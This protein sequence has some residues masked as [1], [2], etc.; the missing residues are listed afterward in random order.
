MESLSQNH[1]FVDG[2]K[3]VAISV[4]A[5]FLCINGFRLQFDDLTTYA[6][7]IRLYEANDFR[8]DRLVEWLTPCPYCLIRPRDSGDHVFP[9]F[10]GGTRKTR[11]CKKCNDNFGHRFEGPVSNDLAP[12]IVFL[13]FSGYKHNRLVMHRRA[14]VDETTGVEYDIDSE[15]RS[16]PNK[17]YLIRDED[18]KV[19]QVVARNSSEAQKIV[20][21][22]KA[23]GQVKEVIER[24]ETKKGLRPP[25]RNTCINV[26]KEMRQLALKMCA[27]VGQV[28]VPEIGILDESCR[29]FLLDLNPGTSPVRQVYMR[30]P[31]IDELRPPLAHVAYIEG[32]SSSAKCFGFVQLFGGAF[33]L[34][35][36]LSSY[37]T[38][39]D[40][41]ALGIL[42]VTTFQEQFREV[43]RLHLPEAPQFGS[44]NDI[45]H[46]FSEWGASINAQVQAAFGQNAIIFGTS[47]K[48]SVAGVKVTLPLLWIE[49]ALEI[50][51][52]MV[53]SMRLLMGEN[54]WR[55]VR[56]MSISY[57]VHKQAWLGSIDLPDCTGSLDRSQHA[58]QTE[59]SLTEADIPMS[60]NP[61]WLK[62]EDPDDYEAVA[63]NVIV[64]ER[65]DISSDSI[66]FSD[67]RAGT[68]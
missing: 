15:Q 4:T 22:L 10:L 60:R 2:N 61:S 37:Y 62:V 7:L 32:D 12:V 23:K 13:S 58:L 3:R 40:F 18:G 28:V 48:Q 27:A 6:F 50:K 41:A 11:C 34:Y 53:P 5:A 67:L 57:S 68:K 45:E 63:E 17:P 33:Q 64:V 30:Y 19:N 47:Q 16:F 38:G 59:I 1:P 51:L 44:Q 8:F 14:W 36:P 9:D 39:R 21:S 46:Y 31:S 20:A 35:A 55:P 25:L 24:R 56:S 54:F 42:D 43:E 65:R 66:C 52:A 26:G 49:Y 29:Q